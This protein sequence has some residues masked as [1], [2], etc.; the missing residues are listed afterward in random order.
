MF[1]LPEYPK[2]S[3]PPVSGEL[4]RRA[5]ISILLADMAAASAM[6]QP[7]SFCPHAM[8]LLGRNDRDRKEQC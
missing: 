8:Y 7:L 4:N 3:N 5:T 6:T 2:K 1:Q